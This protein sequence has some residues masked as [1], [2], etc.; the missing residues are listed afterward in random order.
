MKQLSSYIFYPILSSILGFFLLSSCGKSDNPD[1]PTISRFTWTYLGVNYTANQDT[2]YINNVGPTPTIVAGTGSNFL[3]FTRRFYFILTSFNPGT[4]SL[5]GVPAPNNF[6][7]IDDAGFNH[8]G[9]SGSLTITANSN[10][11]MSGN[12]SGMM[13]GPSGTNP[14]SGDFTNMFIKP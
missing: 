11:R 13:T 1:N 3:T 12:F 7:Y 4:Y 14:V 5:A 6:M 8:G 10:N 9:T 2:G